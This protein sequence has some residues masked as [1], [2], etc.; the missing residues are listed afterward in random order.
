MWPVV[1]NFGWFLVKCLSFMVVLHVVVVV[2][3]V[4]VVFPTQMRIW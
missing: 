2:V 3:V 4:V 1:V